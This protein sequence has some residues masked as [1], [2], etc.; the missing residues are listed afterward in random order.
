MQLVSGRSKGMLFCFRSVRAVTEILAACTLS[1]AIAE[2]SSSPPSGAVAPVSR[3]QPTPV[4]QF[5]QSGDVP[6]ATGQWERLQIEIDDWHVEPGDTDILVPGSGSS[7]VAVVNCVV[8]A[9]AGGTTKILNTGDYWSVPSQSK[10]TVTVKPPVR[11][12]V[13]RTITGAPVQAPRRSKKKM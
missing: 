5:S 2:T 3:H 8:T 1:S 10:L 13:L 9:T 4:Q 12:A 6:K 7:I 11:S